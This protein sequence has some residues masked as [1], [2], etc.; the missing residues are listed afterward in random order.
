MSGTWSQVC[1]GVTKLEYTRWPSLFSSSSNACRRVEPIGLKYIGEK[2]LRQSNYKE[3]PN[4][5]RL[6]K[7][8]KITNLTVKMGPRKP[9]INHEIKRD[10]L[11]MQPQQDLQDGVIHQEAIRC[12]TQLRRVSS[13]LHVALVQVGQEPWASDRV[14]TE[15]FIAELDSGIGEACTLACCS[16][17]GD[18]DASRDRNGP[19]KGATAHA[20][21]VTSSKCI[22]ISRGVDSGWEISWIPEE[23]LDVV[24]P[25][26]VGIVPPCA[27]RITVGVPWVD[28]RVVVDFPV[29]V[30]FTTVLDANVFVTLSRTEGS[31]V[32]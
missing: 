20:V 15:A 23:D 13:T 18:S 10:V 31:T 12:A 21:G 28:R 24:W 19:F 14:T 8:T 9:Q 11:D 1:G 26:T 7:I 4:M 32:L 16:T 29:A 17:L 30:A 3:L 5:Y 22:T 27:D 2:V 6:N 25:T